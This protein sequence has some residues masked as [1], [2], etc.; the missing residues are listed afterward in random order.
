MAS[1]ATLRRQAKEAG[2]SKSAILAATTAEELQSVIDD[3]AGHDNGSG[4]KK[5]GKRAVKKAAAAKKKTTARKSASGNSSGRKSAPA[6]SKKSGTAKRQT[7]T[8]TS[9]SRYVPKGGRNTLDSVDF[10]S[11]DGWNPREGSAPDRIIRA[12]KKARGNREKAFEALKGDVKDFV[13]PKKADGTKRTKDEMHDMLKYRISRTLWDFAMRTGQH[14]SATNRVEYGTG[15]TGQGIWKPAKRSGSRKTASA[16]SGAKKRSQGRAGAS[17]K[18][19]GRKKTA[20]RSR[21]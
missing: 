17:K 13:N 2:I 16:G 3:H 20:S 1:L 18:A 8:A 7:T 5:S 10:N 11:T 6:R 19:S 15:G 21:R 4:S 14:E 9:G 12:L